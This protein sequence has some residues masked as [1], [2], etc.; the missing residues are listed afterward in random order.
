MF[1]LR[2]D[3]QSLMLVGLAGEMEM[4]APG[5]LNMANWSMHCLGGVGVKYV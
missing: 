4:V 2:L 3:W 1:N 5:G